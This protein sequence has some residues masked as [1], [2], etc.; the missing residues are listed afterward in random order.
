MDAARAKNRGPCGV[1]VVVGAGPYG[2]SVAAHLRAAGVAVRVFGEVMASWRHP[3]AT[4]MFLKSTPRA[5]DLST[6]KPGGKLADYRREVGQPE[7]TEFTP[8]SCEVFARYGKWFAD[9]FAGEIEPNH[10]ARVARGR[11]GFQVMLRG[12]ERVEAAA[13]VLAA[14][15]A[16]LA[17][18]PDELVPLA[19]Q[20]RMGPEAVL[21]HTSQQTDLSRYGGR[22]VVVVGGGQSA[23]ESAALLYELGAE[24]DVLVRSDRVRWGTPPSARRP[25]WQRIAH[26]SSP[27]GPGWAL[28]GLC[29]APGLVR[30]LPASQRLWLHR[31]AL[32]PSGSWWLR[33]RVEN[34]V[35]VHLQRRITRAR[36]D[37][38]TARL[39]LA[40]D[41]GELRTDHVLAA[42]GYRID[43]DALSLL[44][45]E[46]RRAIAR[47]PGSGAPR[48]S[49]G[50]ESSVSGLYFAGSMAAPT[51]GPMLRFVAGTGF[52]ARRITASLCSRVGLMV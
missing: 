51:F 22:R 8:I 48:L 37:G 14:G 47:V 30:L 23:L 34:V 17:Y 16:P 13:V 2:L 42:T 18:V 29:W 39:T 4:G 46:L 50:L 45:P 9:H 26:P 19:P 5:T 11:H 31:R 38:S 40:G 27:L 28:R 36:L 52:A 24:V 7:L 10:V 15:L 6:P 20:G 44:A 1:V 33:D 49:P 32:G 12:G 41:A 3:A 21:S 35:P 43:V 25:W